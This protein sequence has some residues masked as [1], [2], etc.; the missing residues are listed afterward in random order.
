[1]YLFVVVDGIHSVRDPHCPDTHVFIVKL[2]TKWQ[3]WYLTAD[4]HILEEKRWT[5]GGDE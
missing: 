4:D 3:I 2:E 5:K 1:M